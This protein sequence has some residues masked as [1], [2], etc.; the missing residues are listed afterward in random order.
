MFK[1]HDVIFSNRP[2]SCFFRN[3][4]NFRNITGAPYNAHWRHLR[5]ICIS[6][7]FTQKR[8]D[9]YKESRLE[10][11]RTSIKELFEET[12]KKGPVD[13]HAWLHRLL[14]NNLTRVIMNRRYACSS[15]WSFSGVE[16]NYWENSCHLQIFAKAVNLIAYSMTIVVAKDDQICPCK[17]PAEGTPY[18]PLHL[19]FP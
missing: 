12:D 15:F 7:L 19:N 17:F 2:E 3:F 13:I 18:I 8:L 14:S 16:T 9:N 4:T 5:K 11:I 1:T 6:E 10:E